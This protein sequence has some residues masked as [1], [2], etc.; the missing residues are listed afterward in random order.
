MDIYEEIKATCDAMAAAHDRL[1]VVSGEADETRD[2]EPEAHYFLKLDGKRTGRDFKVYG[3]MAKMGGEGA[4]LADFAGVLMAVKGEAAEAF[5][6]VRPRVEGWSSIFPAEQR[7]A[8][9]ELWA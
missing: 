3:F 1:E 4:A 7:G 5:E 9:V 8:W 6:A 2:P